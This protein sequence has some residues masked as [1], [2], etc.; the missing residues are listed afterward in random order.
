MGWIYNGE[1]LLKADKKQKNAEQAYNSQQNINAFLANPTGIPTLAVGA[2]ALLGGY[3]IGPHI[4]LFI[5]SFLSLPEDVKT[6][7][8]AG[9]QAGVDAAE[10]TVEA[11]L[12]PV[13]DAAADVNDCYEKSK[14]RLGYI[15]PKVWF[16]PTSFPLYVVCM[17][18]K[19]Y[20]AAQARNLL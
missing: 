13:K 12:K 5:M 15:G 10:G 6:A 4:K 20:T 1:E 7:I 16:P 9:V 18:K 2:L 8:D 19:G 14:V 3:V 17:L 11:I